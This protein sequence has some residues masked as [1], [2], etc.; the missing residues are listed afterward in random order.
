P[1]IK[2]LYADQL[3]PASPLARPLYVLINSLCRLIRH[4]CLSDNPSIVNISPLSTS[5]ASATCPVLGFFF[6]W[7]TNLKPVILRPFFT[8][9]Y[10]TFR[11]D[12]SLISLTAK[13]NT[14]FLKSFILLYSFTPS[15][16]CCRKTPNS[17]QGVFL[18]ARHWVSNS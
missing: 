6:S 2:S 5:R 1:T 3:L 9:S 11:S 12:F 16:I 18:A 8:L 17:K 14:R 7:T 13:S 15:P 10:F 4:S